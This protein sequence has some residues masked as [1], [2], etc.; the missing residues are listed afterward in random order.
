ML[1]FDEQTE[2]NLQCGFSGTPKGGWSGGGGGGAASSKK[3]S[4]TA[5]KAIQNNLVPA[6]SRG[7]QLR[8][9]LGNNAALDKLNSR[10]RVAAGSTS[11]E[12][13]L[14]AN[15]N[16]RNVA[17]TLSRVRAVGAVLRGEIESK[18][19]QKS[20]DRQARKRGTDLN[21]SRKTL[22]DPTG[23]DTNSSF[24]NVVT[25]RSTKGGDSEQRRAAQSSK[26]NK[27]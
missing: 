8:A 25:G 9:K 4:A 10:T 11:L 22:Y 5:A 20:I 15:A 16:K 24:K 13:N 3:A 18:A 17:K 27:R 23:K 21:V 12:R 14:A 1:K 19:T 26:R 7:E 2:E 6:T